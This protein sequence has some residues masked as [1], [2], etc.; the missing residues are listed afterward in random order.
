MEREIS[1]AQEQKQKMR[2]EIWRETQQQQQP[3]K[4]WSVD[5]ETQGDGEA[6]VLPS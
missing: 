5:R 3:W 4:R 6:R 2:G 1:T